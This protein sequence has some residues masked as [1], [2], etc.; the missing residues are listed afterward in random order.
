V[1]GAPGAPERRAAGGAALYQAC[2]P[3]QCGQDTE[4]LTS[5]EKTK[6]HEHV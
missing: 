1:N 3:P 4:V 2:V 5:P 6:P